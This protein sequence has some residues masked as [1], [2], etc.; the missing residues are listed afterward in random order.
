MKGGPESGF[1]EPHGVS[2]ELRSKSSYGRKGAWKNSVEEWTAED[3]TEDLSETKVFTTSS[4]PTENHVTPGQSIDLVAL[5][6]KPA[7]PTQASEVSSFETSQQQGFGQ[8]LVFTN[9]QHNNQMAPGT[10][11]ST[12]A[13]SYSSQSLSSVLGSGFGELAQSKMVNISNSQILDKLKPPGLSPFPDASSTQQSDSASPPATT[14]AWD[15]K[16]SAPQPSVLSRVDFKAQPE[17]SPVLSQLSQRQQH[18]TQA[19]S[20]PPPG[21]E[22]FSSLAKPR[23]STARDGPSTVSRLLQ[24][25]NMAVESI[26]SA[27]QP[28]PKHIKLPKRRYLQLL[29]FPCPQW[30]C[31]A[32]QMSRGSMFSLGPWNL[33]Q[34]HFSLSLDQHLQLVKIVIKFLSACTRSL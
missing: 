17:P 16:P 12:S 5:L 4:V 13:S 31:P 11:N 29:R 18:Q 14:A 30:K 15:L 20:V 21:L 26:A 28:Q 19:V 3:W 34:S 1:A 23:E 10:T 9:S 33:D 27:H 7:P 25:P 6:H 22:S 8:A 32:L 2:Q 24:L